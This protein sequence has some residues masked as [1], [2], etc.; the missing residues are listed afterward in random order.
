MSFNSPCFF[1]TEV[2][3]CT[4]QLFI[5]ATK[6]THFWSQHNLLH[7]VIHIVINLANLTV[8]TTKYD[9]V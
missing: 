1:Y 4:F 6:V 2:Y 3:L 7:G 5:D 9:Y 8:T